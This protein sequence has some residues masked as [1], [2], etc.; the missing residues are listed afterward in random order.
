MEETSNRMPFFANRIQEM[1]NGTRFFRN[2]V[3]FMTNRVRE[4]GNGTRFFIA[5]C[6]SKEFRWVAEGAMTRLK[7][8]LLKNTF[9]E[10]AKPPAF[11][12]LVART[13][14]LGSI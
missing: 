1:R 9:D 14:Y 2:S 7:A 4:I 8:A 13:I 6:R 5:K 12:P 3:Q 10:M 11:V